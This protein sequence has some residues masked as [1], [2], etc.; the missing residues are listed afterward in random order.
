MGVQSKMFQKIRERIRR[1]KSMEAALDDI[2]AIAYDYD[3]YRE[4][5]SLMELIDELADIGL[6]GL[7][8]EYH[9]HR[10]IT[11]EDLEPK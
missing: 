6:L 7:G 8:G 3:G 11:P 5:K 1:Y 2:V 10:D 9:L 4:A